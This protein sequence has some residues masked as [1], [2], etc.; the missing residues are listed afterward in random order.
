MDN[1]LELE[2]ALQAARSAGQTLLA[3]Y[4]RFQAIPDAPATISTD[5]DRESQRIILEY[6]HRSFP[7]D[8]LCAEETSALL[9]GVPA[10]GPRLWIVD[11]IDGTRGFARKNGEFSVMI[12]FVDHG[13]IA[14]GVVFEPA[15]GRLTYARR[16]GGCWRRDGADTNP[17]VCRVTSVSEL[18]R[19]SLVQSHSR[20]DGSRSRELLALKPAT[21]TETYSAGIKLARVARGEADIYLNNYPA[22]H[23]W[24]VCA[25]HVLVNEAGGRVTGLQ[26]QMIAYGQPGARHAYGLL[27]S[28]GRLHTQALAAL[29]A[30]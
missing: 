15:F 14:V 16:G 8:A 20:K 9:P 18:S 12:G 23:E 19:A 22:F 4:A 29:S 27:A 25:G 21:V 1:Q 28:N 13:E 26:G 5:A 3:S 30:N 24:D 10:N 6:L 7:T 11:P 2:A 17:A